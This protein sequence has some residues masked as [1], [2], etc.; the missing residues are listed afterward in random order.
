MTSTPSLA[1]LGREATSGV[2]AVADAVR[3]TRTIEREVATGMLTKA[4][5]SP[6]TVADFAVQA[7]I[8]ARLA[9]DFPSDSLV[10][11]EDATALRAPEVA[12]LR[13]RVIDIVQRVDSS[14]Q[15][16]RILELIDRGA[17]SPNGRFWTLDPIDGTKG[18]LRGG[19]YAVALA[20]IAEGIVQ[21]GVLGCP[22]FSLE[23]SSPSAIPRNIRKDGGIAVAVRNRGAWW[24]SAIDRP[25]VRLTVSHTADP[26]RARVVHSFEAA[27]GDFAQFHRVLE[28]L[29]I[30]EV[31]ILMDSQVK[32]LAIAIGRA[33]LLFR[34]PTREG[35]HDAIWDQAAGSLLID[36]AGGRVT[37]L[38]GRSLDFSAG[39]R[40]LK[41]DGVVASNGRLHDAVML[42]L[43]QSQRLAATPVGRVPPTVK[44]E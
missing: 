36:E 30:E 3:L 9:R 31:P 6:V 43:R 26:T 13:A 7:L 11:E 41:N 44:S 34:F 5:A 16:D 38:K 14:L 33:D 2:Q 29:R 10:A 40:L 35:F 22:R 18:L 32:H 21:L 25:L 4:D 19:Q 20:L 39:R 23:K 27:H 24:T 12:D 37:D 42:G 17:G 15:S 1:D 8:A 28:T